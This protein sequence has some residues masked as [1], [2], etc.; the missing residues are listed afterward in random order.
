MFPGYHPCSCSPSLLRFD[1]EFARA[2]CSSHSNA[3]PVH[4][5]RQVIQIVVF[6][7]MIGSWGC[8]ITRILRMI[9]V[10]ASYE[11]RM[12]DLHHTYFTYDGALGCFHAAVG[13]VR[14][15]TGVALIICIL[16]MVVDM[17]V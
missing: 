9:V 1:F 4:A 15:P 8:L 17:D 5:L 12:G 13:S 10:L 16:R 2:S 6:V 11:S 7:C 3:L 14:G